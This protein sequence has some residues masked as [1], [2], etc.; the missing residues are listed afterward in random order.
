MAFSTRGFIRMGSLHTTSSE[1]SFHF[2][3]GWIVI[4]QL[5]PCTAQREVEILAIH[6]KHVLQGDSLKLRPGGAALEVSMNE[7]ARILGLVESWPDKHSF[8]HC[9]CVAIHKLRD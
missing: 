1:M 3:N 9:P 6:V 8:D 7:L 2:E 5:T 4:A